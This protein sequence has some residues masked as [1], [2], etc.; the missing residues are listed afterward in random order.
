[1]SLHEPQPPAFSP[2]SRQRAGVLSHLGRT[3]WTI[4][5][6]VFVGLGVI[7]ALLPL[8]PTTIFLILAAGCFA[9]SSP[10]LEVWLLNHRQFGP[11]LRAW[12]ADGAIGPRAKAMA[13]T[14]MAAGYALFYWGAR[15]HL[16]LALGVGAAMAA[17]AAYVLSRPAPRTEQRPAPLD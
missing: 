8:M 16:P 1:M 17:C 10:R 7:G 12:R 4:L 9:R 5:G 6:L 2:P 15:P 13:T 3:A 14:G 11:T